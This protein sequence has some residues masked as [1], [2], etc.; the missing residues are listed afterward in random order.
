MMSVCAD[1][2]KGIQNRKMNSMVRSFD[3][4]LKF[5]FILEIGIVVLQT[6]IVFF[7]TTLNSRF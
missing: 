5:V 2:E 6:K 3:I 7:T 4:R 1:N